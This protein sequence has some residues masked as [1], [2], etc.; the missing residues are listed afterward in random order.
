MDSR[1][2]KVLWFGVSTILLLGLILLADV[3]LFLEAL[4]Q[5]KLIYLL[6]ALILGILPLSIYGFT[7]YR[8]LNQVGAEVSYL[9]SLRMFLGG[10]FMNSVTPIGQFGG[11]PFMAYVIKN[12]TELE[13]EEAFSTVLSADLINS[14]PLITFLTG[15]VVYMLFLGNVSDLL[16]QLIFAALIMIFVGSGFAYLLWFRSGTIESAILTVVGRIVETV[17]RGQNL[18][19][20]LEKRFEG[21]QDA[22][23]TIGENPQHLILTA[24]VVHLEFVFRVLTLYLVLFSL[25]IT[26]DFAP[27]YFILAFGAVANFA[28]TP[29]GSGVSEATYS[30]LISLF[31]GIGLATAAVAG[32]LLRLMIYWPGLIL[33]YI[34]LMSLGGEQ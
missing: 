22:F 25:G 7:W 18:Y 21:V 15:G 14:V 19:N 5:A 29:G 12:N 10:Q 24:I 13:Y 17:G 1:V 32:I 23:E 3:S 2:V 4:G 26:A 28:P 33:G 34:G 16:T 30:G 9:K 6:P 8:F 27:L 31:L 20:G 11:E